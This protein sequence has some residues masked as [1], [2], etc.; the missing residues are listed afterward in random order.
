MNNFLRIMTV[1]LG[2][3][4]GLPVQAVTVIL[5]DSQSQVLAPQVPLQWRSISPS[6][7]DHQVVG[8]ARVQIRLDTRAWI[9]K[10]GRIFLALP[11]QPGTSVQAQWQA[12]GALLS[13]Q[14]S[15]GSRGLVWQGVITQAVME[16]VLQ[17]AVQTDGRMLQSPQAL[18]FHFELDLP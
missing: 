4:V 10:T 1:V 5:D 17:V 18:R 3:W 6:Q 2:L 15:S 7:G 11:A 16:D 14:L 9:G 13:G 8:S 12:Q